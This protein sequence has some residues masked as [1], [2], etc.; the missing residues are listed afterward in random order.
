[1]MFA[2]SDTTNY[3]NVTTTV[4]V[5]TKPTYSVTFNANGGTGDPPSQAAT[6][7]N[8]TF[9]LPANPFVKEGYSFAGWYDGTYTYQAGMVY[10]MPADNV[11][12]YAQWDPVTYT[13]T[14]N[15]DGGTNHAANPASYTIETSTI[16]LQNATK[17]GY[18]FA[19]W[20]DAPTG[21]NEVTSTPQGSTGNKTLYA[22]WTP[23]T[24]TVTFDAN[25]GGTPS[26]A[27]KLVT[28]DS[29]YGELPTVTREGYDFKGWFMAASG[30]TETTADT[31]V[32]TASDHTLYAQ[33]AQ[34]GC[35]GGNSG[36][37]S[38]GSD[39]PAAPSAPT[40]NTGVD[41]LINGKTETAAT[42]TISQEGDRT[43]T[44]IVI[45][46]KK[47]EEK[48]VQEGNN[49]VVTI[50]VSN[51]TEVIIGILN[52]QTVKNM[53]S[54][55]AVLVITTGQV[56]YTLPAAQINIDAVF[57]QIGREVEL[58]DI[59]VSVRISEPPAEKI[60]I[61]EDAANQNHYQIVVP[62]IEF[63]ITCTSGDKTVE[64][65]KFNAYVERLVAIP[66]GIDPSKITTGVIVN[67]DGTFY[68]V[69]TE[70]IV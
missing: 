52:G 57:Q 7:E 39:T 31:T 14:Y 46:E 27:N 17:T 5:T 30:G 62:P 29:T 13:I 24:F 18:T 48:L 60:R 21:G 56:T 3:N 64:V 8:G 40:A 1:M 55:E 69:P 28:Y 9:T 49:T 67:P 58:R 41:I 66:E 22:R 4:S 6:P 20:F 26:P 16:N 2:P 11:E 53:E 15:L 25:G 51:A 45:D 44:N 36:G 19:G 70:I 37:A 33:W 68:H 63:E 61:I 47:V 43:I 34:R 10:T 23:N 12:F 59:T 42:A 50:P 35:S 54:K 38:G 65:T 32:N